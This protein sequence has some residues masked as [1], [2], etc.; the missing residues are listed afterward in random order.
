MILLR[1]DKHF[2]SRSDDIRQ[3]ISRLIYDDKLNIK[4]MYFTESDEYDMICYLEFENLS[5]LYKSVI[6]I[7]EVYDGLIS[8]YIVK[9]HDYYD[10]AIK[11]VWLSDAFNFF[12]PSSSTTQ[13]VHSI[14]VS[15]IGGLIFGSILSF[16]IFIIMMVFHN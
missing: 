4:S 9:R 7:D 11:V 12:K 13:K 16:L 1:I 8:Y 2:C 6:A 5:D 10:E 14:R 3:C 15:I